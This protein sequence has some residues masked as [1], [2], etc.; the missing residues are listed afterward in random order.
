MTDACRVL[1]LHRQKLFRTAIGLKRSE[2]KLEKS[3]SVLVSGDQSIRT[4]TSNENKDHHDGDFDD[5]D[6]G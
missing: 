6:F 3:K 2:K 4:T 5:D 1:T